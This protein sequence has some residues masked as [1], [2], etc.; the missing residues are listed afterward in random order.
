MENKD[1]PM[2]IQNILGYNRIN[3]GQA[4]TLARWFNAQTGINMDSCFCSASQRNNVK[5][6]VI[7][8]L[9]EINK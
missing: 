5:D 4:K 8:Y 1:I 3:K 9:E 6:V 7:N 2:N